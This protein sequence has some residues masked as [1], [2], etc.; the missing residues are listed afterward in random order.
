MVPKLLLNE[1]HI[2][3]FNHCRLFKKLLDKNSNF[4]KSFL[5]IMESAKT[6]LWG[7]SDKS[8]FVSLILFIRIGN[9]LIIKGPPE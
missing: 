4:V 7:T 3:M 5:N 6:L 1:F 2:K 9:A 8:Q